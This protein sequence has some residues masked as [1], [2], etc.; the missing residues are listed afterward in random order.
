MGFD[1]IGLN[2]DDKSGEYFRNNIWWWPPLWDYVCAV[3]SKVLSK[4]DKKMGHYNDGHVISEKKAKR[5]ARILF[6]EVTSGRT[7]E[8]EQVFKIVTEHIPDVVCKF[9]KGTGKVSNKTCVVCEG[10]GRHRPWIS[11][12][13]FSEENVLKFIEFCEHSG[14][15]QI[16]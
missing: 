9:C 11:R 15:F 4:T 13:F 8:Y 7:K 1:L 16:W 5:M 3:C 10:K 12:C 14:G 2:P 6:R